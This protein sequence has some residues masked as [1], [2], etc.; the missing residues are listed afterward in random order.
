[1]YYPKTYA[2]ILGRTD[3]DLHILADDGRRLT[4]PLARRNGGDTPTDSLRAGG[5]IKLYRRLQDAS[6]HF[7]RIGR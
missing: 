3:C 7:R 1:M 5:R 4:I 2:T 6:L